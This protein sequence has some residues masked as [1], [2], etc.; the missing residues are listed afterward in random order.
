MSVSI[1]RGEF[2]CVFGTSGGGKTSLLNIIGTIDKPTKGDLK[3][4]GVRVGARTPD[5]QLAALRLHQMGFVF[6]TFNLLSALTAQENVEMPMLLAGRLSRAER[7]ARARSL[8]QRVGLGARLDHVPAQ[9]SGGEQQRVTIARAVAN[10]PALLLLD[11]P[12]GDLDSLN[13][14]LVLQL[15]CELHR[16]G[17]TLVMVTHDVSLKHFAD[18]VIWMR[19]GRIQRIEA[20]PAQQ[21]ADVRER[22]QRDVAALERRREQPTA[23]AAAAGPGAARV[24]LAHT[25]LRR[26]RDYSTYAAAVPG[27]RGPAAVSAGDGAGPSAAAAAAQAADESER[28]QA[29]HTTLLAGGP[30]PARPAPAL[31]IDA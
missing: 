19:D 29:S 16:D 21:R 27:T 2:I 23:A 30:A 6:Q 15:L 3:L 28:S 13:S 5:A 20:V 25:Q 4:C 1:A 22:L 31:L 10:E 11:E 26:P 8:L 9:L 7:A 24:P 14:A 18:R 12:T 17:L